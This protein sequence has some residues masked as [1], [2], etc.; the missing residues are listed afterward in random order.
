MS[1]SSPAGYFGWEPDQRLSL[2]AIGYAT[3][4]APA[5]PCT[6]AP[7]NPILFSS[8][9]ATRAASAAP[10]IRRVFQVGDR[11]FLA[12]H[13]WSVTAGC[14]RL[15]ADPLALHLAAQVAGRQ[16]DRRQPEARADRH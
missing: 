4:A 5:G 14:H 8:T 3:C 10:A 6:D 15:G 13:A 7:E 1:C 2:Y 11:Y 9:R 16:A 12:Y